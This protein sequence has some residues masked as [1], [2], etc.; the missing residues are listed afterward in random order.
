[1]GAAAPDHHRATVAGEAISF[2]HVTKRFV[3]PDGAAYTAI[4]DISFPVA[5]GQFVSIVGPTGCGKSTLLNLAAG[6]LQADDG[7][8]EIFERP[9]VGLNPHATYMFQQDVLLPWKSAEE[10][11]MLGLLFRRNNEAA[12]RTRAHELLARVGLAGFERH[13][14]HQLSGGMRKRV[15][16]AQNLIV[17]PEILLMDEPF[18][19]LDVQTRQIM[20]NDVLRLW[21][22]FRKTVLFVTHDLEEAI[23]LAD[24]VIVLSSG[25]AARVIGD[26][27]I[28]L[29]RPRDVSEV[30]LD[31][32]F[33]EVYRTI[34]QHLHGEVKKA[35][36]RAR[37][38]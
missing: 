36:E 25:P 22:E 35:Y 12:A 4:E 27:T 17:N 31:R 9:L 26:Y 34:W 2:L 30:R 16:L 38:P 15:A 3:S 24:R 21:S 7:A 14:P 5:R 8:V 28:D 11:V 32:A 20:E 1:M 37:A 6:L 13:Y 23:A 19:A 18:S 33:L 10:N 29:S